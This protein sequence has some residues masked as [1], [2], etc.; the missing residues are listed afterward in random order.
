MEETCPVAEV[1]GKDSRGRTRCVGPVSRLE[2]ELSAPAR[3]KCDELRSK[4]VVLT[5]KVEDLGD[6]MEVL[7]GGFGSLCKIVKDLQ[8]SSAVASNS[9]GFCSPALE[10]GEDI[11][12]SRQPVTPSHSGS[13]ALNAGQNNAP[14]PQSCSAARSRVGAKPRC[15]LLNIETEVIATGE[16]CTGP[17]SRLFHSVAVPDHLEKVLLDEILLP[18]EITVRANTFAGSFREVGVGG[19]VLHP[20]ILTRYD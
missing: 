7:I 14:S 12:A 18:D 11:A 16:V 13:P 8:S 3:A 20:K 9:L 1:F 10:T 6:K 15:A 2:V 5:Q 19:F 17:S 4:D